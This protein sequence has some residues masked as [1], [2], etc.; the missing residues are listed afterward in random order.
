MLHFAELSEAFIVPEKK[1]KNNN[2]YKTKQVKEPVGLFNESGLSSVNQRSH[3]PKA[4]AEAE[5]EVE[6]KISYKPKPLIERFDQNNNQLTSASPSRSGRQA[7]K[8]Y[9]F[10][11]KNKWLIEIIDKIHP[12]F[13]TDFIENALVN[14]VSPKTNNNNSDVS[15]LLA[16][17]I[18]VI[19]IDI[20][21]RFWK[22]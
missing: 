16:F 22:K 14:F 1:S 19:F 5:A 11:I 21:I 7:G 9:T 2:K 8:E 3:H 6:P 4:E 10:L 13:R 12:L 20:I 18:F 17:C 15:L